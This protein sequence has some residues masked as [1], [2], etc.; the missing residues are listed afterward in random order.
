MINLAN[1]EAQIKQ[2]LEELLEREVFLHPNPN[3]DCDLQLKV[4]GQLHCIVQLKATGDISSVVSATNRTDDVLVVVPHMNAAAAKYCREHQISWV[5]LSGNARIVTDKLFVKSQGKPNRFRRKR[6]TLNP[7][8]PKSSRLIR[9]LL[10]DPQ[11]TFTQ[12]ELI[13]LT[14]LPQSLV[15]RLVRSL[16]E[17]GFLTDSRL[18]SV[19]RPNALLEAWAEA[20]RFESHEIVRGHVSSTNGP[21]L[22]HSVSKGLSG[23]GVKCG[24]TGLAGA[25]LLDK[26]ASFR[27]AT[28][29]VDRIP[30]TKE[31]EA[32]EFQPT[33]RGPNVW[34]VCPRDTALLSHLKQQDGINCQSPLQIF[35]DLQSHPERA[36][37]AADEIRQRHLNWGDDDR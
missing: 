16:R 21:D 14:N 37:E 2:V 9:Q 1:A 5:D 19:R 20:Y 8:A 24:A 26:F 36:Q 10:L 3:D 17:T 7:F 15:S 12:K 25:W 23:L 29:Y 28:F 33:K 31:L 35:L 32:L 27:L 18:V 6:A 13:E 30:T 34:L 22:L 4:D 11:R